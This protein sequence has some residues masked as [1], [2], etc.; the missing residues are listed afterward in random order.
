MSINTNCAAC[1]AKAHSREQISKYADFVEQYL[2]HGVIT[3]WLD[4]VGDKIVQ[5]LCQINQ[6]EGT[7][8]SV[9]IQRFLREWFSKNMATPHPTSAGVGVNLAQLAFT[10]SG[11][12]IS[13]GNS[14]FQIFPSSGFRVFAFMFSAFDV[15]PFRVF[16]RLLWHFLILFGLSRSLNP[17]SVQS[18]QFWSVCALISSRFPLYR[19]RIPG[20]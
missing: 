4:M 9:A 10:F 7:E 12:T 14:W 18:A 16:P 19:V 6:Q 20:F 11:L 15:L 17:F 8:G 2:T 1:N 13:M 3:S 5:G